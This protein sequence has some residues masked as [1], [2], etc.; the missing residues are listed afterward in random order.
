MWTLSGLLFA[1]LFVVAMLSTL[2]VYI[3]TLFERRLFARVVAEITIRAVH[4]RDPFFGDARRADLF[5]RFFDLT[6]VQKSV[7]SLLIGGFTIML[8]SA[9]GLIV[10]SFYH[11]FFLACQYHPEFQSKPNHPHPLFTGFIQ[12]SLAN[13]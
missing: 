2:R 11:P 5:N 7:P 10:T 4:A 8:Q 3:M 9:V 1:L 12:A 13:C 6:V